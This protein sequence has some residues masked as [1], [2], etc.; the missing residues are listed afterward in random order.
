MEI[1]TTI[2]SANA[3]LA[4]WRA[5]SRAAATRHQEAALRRR[6]RELELL[7]SIASKRACEAARAASDLR[8]WL[9]A[10]S[11]SVAIETET[12]EAANHA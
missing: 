6:V 4:D 3:T 11:A 5:A 8:D 1:F 10:Q 9:A 7:L 12:E 2:E